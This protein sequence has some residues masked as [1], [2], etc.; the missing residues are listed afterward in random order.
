MIRAFCKEMKENM[1]RIQSACICQTLL[2]SVKEPVS[3]EESAR[4]NHEEVAG[5][6]QL[7]IKRGI[8]HKLIEEKELPD[9]SV[10]LKIIKQYNAS[11]VGDYLN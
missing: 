11:D 3:R 4:L 8:R 10:M 2:F 1:K 5:Y 9:G 7:L 6:Q